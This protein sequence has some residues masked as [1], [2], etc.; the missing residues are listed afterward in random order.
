M[1]KPTPTKRRKRPIVA[2]EPKG[3]D[4]K[5]I[6]QRI[7]TENLFET[8]ALDPKYVPWMYISNVIQRVF[9]RTLGQSP[10]GPVP[11]KCSEDGS[12][13][14]A[15]L[16]GGYTQNETKFGNAPDAYGAP[17]QFSAPMG[18]VDIY[19]FD[20]KMIFKRSRDGVLWNNEIELFKDTFYS[21]DCT[22]F[23][24]NLKNYAAGITARYQVI[25]WF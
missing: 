5:T 24:F 18:R 11:I 3:Y 15:G 10:L 19:C 25:G 14:V 6:Y 22:T 4:P 23:Q 12:L 21:F 1:A 2:Y 8:F 20:Q 17:I 16:G 13:F 9:A 7:N